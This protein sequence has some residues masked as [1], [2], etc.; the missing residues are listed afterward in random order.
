MAGIVI[1]SDDFGYN[2]EVNQAICLAF[3][4]GYISSTSALV[5]FQSGFQDARKLIEQGE[6]PRSS[7][8]VHL[9]LSEGSPLTKAIQN[10]PRFCE[11]GIFHGRLR[12]RPIVTLA[13][14]EAEAVTS[15]LEAQILKFKKLGFY[16]SHIDS[17]HH[18][19]TEW[20]LIG[21]V[22]LVA[23]KYGI[24]S[25]RPSR[26]LGAMSISKKVYKKLFNL[27]INWANLSAPSYFGDLDDVIYEGG[28]IIDA[29]I[30]VH[31]R[32]KD[33]HLTDLDG[34]D[35][36]AK[37]ARAFPSGLPALSGYP[38]GKGLL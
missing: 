12:D 37:I 23:K 30:M 21:L 6:V 5:N 38:S 2:P 33:G 7:I 1:N 13:R 4:R 36:H 34:S 28:E 9:N 3:K 26:N 32:M 31:A 17:H 20:G 8:G 35:L 18:V 11:N 19:H 24:H 15:E 22:I 29:E 27:R 14:A 10:Q 25:I 16:P